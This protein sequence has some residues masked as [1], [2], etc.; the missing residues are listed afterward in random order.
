MLLRAELP[1]VVVH[2]GHN[3]CCYCAAVKK[4]SDKCISHHTSLFCCLQC[5]QEI[6]IFLPY[7]LQMISKSLVSIEMYFIVACAHC[8]SV[9]GI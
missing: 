7:L 6:T 1:K 9:V 5:V 2:S 4:I 3:F 8:G